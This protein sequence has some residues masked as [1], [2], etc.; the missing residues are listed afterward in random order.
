[1]CIVPSNRLLGWTGLL[2]LP[3]ATIAAMVPQ[4]WMA[5]FAIIT[6]F[7]LV[8]I[9]DIYISRDIFKGICVALPDVVRMT[10]GRDTRIT[11]LIS[12]NNSK[13]ARL[14]LGFLLPRYIASDCRDVH[15]MLP[16]GQGRLSLPWPCRALKRGRYRLEHCCLEAASPLGFWARRHI[17]GMNCEIRV[18]PD[19]G[20]ERKTLAAFFM[21]NMPGIHAWHQI[22]KG[23]DFERLREYM[24]GDSFEDIHWKATAKRRLPISKIYQIEKTQ[25]I[26]V[27]IDS[28]RLGD[29]N[30]EIFNKGL[31]TPDQHGPSRESETTDLQ[32]TILEKYIIA[33]L[34]V[35]MAAERQGDNFGV[36]A[37][38]DRV[39][40]FVPAGTGR[41]HYQSCRDMLYL[42]ENQKVTPDFTQLCTTLGEKIRKRSLLIFLTSLDDPSLAERFLQNI[43]MLRKRHLVMVNMLKPAV[44]DPLFSHPVKG[45]ANDLYCRLAGHIL[46]ES[47]GRTAGTLRRMGVD[48]ALLDND[49]MCLQLIT[50]YLNIKKRQ[51]L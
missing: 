36:A 1:M 41:A 49:N 20:G 39:T 44:A 7:I 30:A 28:S 19:L 16:A 31:D 38:S 8:A 3:A 42:L 5:C 32:D 17:A 24:P 18:Y 27:I 37:F 2:F 6:A 12:G 35:G 10:R 43:D 23:R 47:L 26:Y 40:G 48:L 29:R 21:K 34:A 51:V 4:A 9:A 45:P 11:V 33:A 22:G 13:T 15:V 25:N 14:R 46:W 50:Q